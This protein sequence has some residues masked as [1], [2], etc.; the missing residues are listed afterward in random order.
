MV[1]S[2]Q[3]T[4]PHQIKGVTA[5]NKRCVLKLGEKLY[6]KWTLYQPDVANER[7]V[8][9]ASGDRHFGLSL[10]GGRASDRPTAVGGPTISAVLQRLPR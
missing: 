1:L 9:G 6:V 4:W 5:E 7:A 10:T 2:Q 3:V 8:V